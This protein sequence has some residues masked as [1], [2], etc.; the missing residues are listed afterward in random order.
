MSANTLISRPQGGASINVAT[1]G[2][3]TANGTQAGVIANVPTAG[4]ATAADNA[5][6]INSILAALRGVGIIA[7]S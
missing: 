7:A 1:G 2:R 6:A 5:T 4:S 3:I